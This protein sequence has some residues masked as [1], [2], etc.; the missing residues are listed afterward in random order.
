MKV[1]VLY[2]Y[3]IPFFE[4]SRMDKYARITLT[5]QRMIADGSYPKGSRLPTT[6]QL[7][8]QFGVSKITVKR[9]M[10]ELELMGL[11]T[12]RRGSGTYVTGVPQGVGF[13]SVMLGNLGG[14]TSEHTARGERVD[15]VVH[16]FRKEHPDPGIAQELGIETDVECFFIIRTLLADGIPLQ[17]Q[18]L[19]IPASVAPMLTKQHAMGSIY[20]YMEE[21]L[22]LKVASAHRRVLATHANEEIADH[23]QID[24][25][26]SVLKIFQITYLEDGRACEKSISFHVPGYELLSVVT[27]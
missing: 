6:T 12:R 24:T 7:C 2:S 20:S 21:E 16:S 17:E 18:A 27:R 3:S 10:D 25:S 5:L 26:D 8:Q 22:G 1:H 15:V 13:S 11:I 23:L 14:F 19:Y 9:A 4:S